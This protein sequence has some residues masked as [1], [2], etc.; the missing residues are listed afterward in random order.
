[1]EPMKFSPA[2]EAAC[3]STV[4]RL[5]RDVKDTEHIASAIRSHQKRDRPIAQARTRAAKR[6]TRRKTP[7][8]RCSPPAP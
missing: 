1:M 8:S 5:P 6:N 4:K 3:C 7:T 2:I